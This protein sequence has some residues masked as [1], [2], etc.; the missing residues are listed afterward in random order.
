MNVLETF[1]YYLCYYIILQ[2]RNE[3]NAFVD[4]VMSTTVMRHLMTYL[5]NKGNFILGKHTGLYRVGRMTCMEN[6]YETIII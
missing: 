1:L 4:A 5:K 6:A 3:E 2:E